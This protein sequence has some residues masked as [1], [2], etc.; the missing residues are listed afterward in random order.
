MS[1]KPK[2]LPW[3]S[4]F[5]SI[6]HWKLHYHNWIRFLLRFLSFLSSVHYSCFFISGISKTESLRF[7][8]RNLIPDLEFCRLIPSL[9]PNIWFPQKKNQ[10]KYHY[11]TII[12]QIDAN[13]CQ[14]GKNT[15][16]EIRHWLTR[17][18][19]NQQKKPVM[20]TVWLEEFC[21]CFKFCYALFAL[22]CRF[23]G[24]K[25]NITKQKTPVLSSLASG[26]PVEVP[27]SP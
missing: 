26:P 23:K 6:P 7:S 22:K 19:E 21:S 18:W 14:E 12:E 27:S 24:K 2:R 9:P 13:L 16:T 5:D 25:N 11:R 20:S 15:S 10:G 1:R 3:V 4:G 17:P 8:W